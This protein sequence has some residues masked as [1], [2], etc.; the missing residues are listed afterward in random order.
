[1]VTSEKDLHFGNPLWADHPSKQLPIDVARKDIRTDVAIIGAG[2]SGAMMAEELASA[3]FKVVVLDKRF[4]G[5]GST[6][7]TTAL[8]QFEIDQ[9]L[10]RLIPQIGFD[11]AARAWR[12]SKLCLEGLA[13]RIKML[14]IRC[15]LRLQQSLYLNGNVLNAAALSKELEFRNQIGLQT[16]LIKRKMLLDEYGLHAAAALR[17]YHNY[18]AHPY[19]LSNGF[20][21]EALKKGAH[22]YSPVTVRDLTTSPRRVYLE[23]S[24][25]FTVTARYAIFTTGYEVP[26]Q[27]MDQRFSI[28]S[29]WAIATMKQA[30]SLVK[31][32]PVIWQ[33]SDP[34]LYLRTTPD[35][36]IICGGE[37]EEFSDEEQRNALNKEKIP[38]LQKK[39]SKL[40]PGIDIRADY[41]WSGAFGVTPTGLP[42]IGVMPGLYNCFAVMA[43]GG[44]GITWSRLGAEII[45]NFISGKKEPD[46]DLFR[47]QKK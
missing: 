43:F 12:R 18:T 25:G 17:S 36:R 10:T 22:I 44:N 5:H 30:P 34:Y 9:P 16:E 32:L 45:R 47:F 8:L 20:L 13:V 21:L 31:G 33:A 15:G 35:N 38:V 11:N 3:G 19:H 6:M 39:L 24:Y 29:T 14:G 37:D 27:L 40:L 4:P 7:A 26:E 23:T 28:Y 2:I 46:E 41:A 42:L 1:M